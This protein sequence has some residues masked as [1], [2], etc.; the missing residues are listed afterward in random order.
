TEAPREIRGEFRPIATNVPGVQ[1]G[2]AFPRL[3]Q[4]MDRLVVIR[5]MVG[6]V[7]SP[8]GFQ[9]LRGW[10]QAAPANPGGRPGGGAVVSRL[11]G[12]ADPSVPPSVGLAARTQHV[13]WSDSGR[14][15]FLGPSY[16]PFK[17]DGEMM[18]NL[19]LNGVNAQHLADR[20]RLLAS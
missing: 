2:E 17:L 3:A 9:C 1:I 19:R 15:G 16:A 7:E 5:S 6:A 8:N 4:M 14:P 12:P 11:H 20:R 18:T 10:P 13:P